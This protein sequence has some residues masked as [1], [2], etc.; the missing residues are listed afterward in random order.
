MMARIIILLAVSASFLLSGLA[1]AQEPIDLLY[2]AMRP[3]VWTVELE[4]VC[5]AAQEAGAPVSWLFGVQFTRRTFVVS[6][7]APISG[8]MTL[9][10]MAYRQDAW[11]YPD[12]TT[13]I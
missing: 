4:D 2:G 6:L 9:G 11:L 10:T 13:E 12:D 8:R 3:D 7:F 1:V 5:F